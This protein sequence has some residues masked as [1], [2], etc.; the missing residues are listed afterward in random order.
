MQKQEDDHEFIV[1]LGYTVSH[2]FNKKKA[3]D[4]EIPMEK[5]G[6]RKPLFPMI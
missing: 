2:C 3:M 6:H 4:C 5:E 1:S